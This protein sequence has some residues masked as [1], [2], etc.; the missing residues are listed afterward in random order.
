M[1]Q[2]GLESFLAAQSSLT[3]LLGASR[4]DRTNGIFPMLALRQA[5]LPY[6][7][8]QRVSG[9]PTYSYQG[10]N[11][12]QD[13]RFRFSCYASSQRGA[14]LLA[15]AIKLVFATWTGTFPDGTPVQ[16][17][18]LELEA[19]DSESIPNGTI[20]AVHLDYSFQYLDQS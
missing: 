5:T 7:V 2:D 20:Y 10:A 18:M 6:V 9:K 12:W 14:V 15:E 1:F 16:N 4:S 8:F 17:V 13:A 3:A 11:R 19:D